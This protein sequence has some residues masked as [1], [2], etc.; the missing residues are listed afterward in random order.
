MSFAGRMLGAIRAMGRKDGASIRLTGSEGYKA[1]S[2]EM[3]GREFFDISE[4]EASSIFKRVADWMKKKN[5]P[6]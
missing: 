2:N 1:W 6:R 5:K 3:R 4:K